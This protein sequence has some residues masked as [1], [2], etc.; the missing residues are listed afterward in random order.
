MRSAISWLLIKIISIQI[1]GKSFN[2]RLAC[3]GYN[4]H[5]FIQ[6]K[7]MDGRML[8]QLHSE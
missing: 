3:K 6:I 8:K 5:Q 7:G 1:P 2:W 4:V